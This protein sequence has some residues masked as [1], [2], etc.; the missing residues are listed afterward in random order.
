MIFSQVPQEWMNKGVGKL[1]NKYDMSFKGFR[2][3]SFFLLSLINFENDFAQDNKS[4]IS[5]NALLKYKDYTPF[6]NV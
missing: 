6:V 2:L 4:R 3:L 1:K 5:L